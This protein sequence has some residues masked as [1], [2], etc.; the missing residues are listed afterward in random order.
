MK[1][2][3]IFA[4]L[5]AVTLLLHSCADDGNTVAPMD[6][7]NSSSEN[8]TDDSATDDDSA[9][10][11]S[12]DDDDD[13]SDPSSEVGKNAGDVEVFNSDLI[14]D[15]Y[16]L[17]NDAGN[18]R[19]YL[20]DKKST[21]LYEWDIP[22]GIGNDVELLPDGRLVGIMKADDPKIEYGGQGGKLQFV[23][24]D[25]SIEWNFDY[26]SE[27]YITHHDVELLPNGNL[28]TIVWEKKTM[29]EAELAGSSLGIDVFPEA[30][31]EVDPTTDEIV[32]EWHSWDHLIQDFDNTKENYG[33]V[34]EN[35][36]LINLN[37]VT[38]AEGDI[39]HANGIEYDEVND[40]IYL[41]INF[42]HEVWV[43]DHSTSSEQAA[44]HEG[45]NFGKGG[46]LIYRFGNP[47]AYGNTMG[48]RLFRNNHHPRLL[49]GVDLGK[50]SIFT[51][52][53]GADPQQSTVYELQLPNPLNLS[54][55]TN[56]E[57][58]VAWSFTNA[59]LYSPKVSGMVR[60]PNSNRLITEGDFGAWE[61]TESGEVVWKF[62]GQGFFWRA[63]HYAKDDAAIIALGL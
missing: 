12:D 46:D 27:D 32:W 61:V 42:F 18:D 19:V 34:T 21:I 37:Y 53:N 14:Y 6:D 25:S 38:D 55:N 17:I 15:G 39:M 9:D 36:Q 7:D 63:Y 13:D 11:D 16:V 59:D 60:L 44:S 50:I 22:S 30:I 62:I 57:P 45:G 3:Y 43:I 41:S 48:E 33:T 54:P 47:E 52:G 24:P 29:E 10:D 5:F 28:I 56:N 20:M 58:S 51:N 4:A 49:D 1:T 2:S 26:S 40:L 23:N 31:I 8:P 35:P